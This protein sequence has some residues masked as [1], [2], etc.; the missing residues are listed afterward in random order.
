[1]L[2]ISITIA[3]TTY[4]RK[5][6]EFPKMEKSFTLDSVSTRD[7]W[8]KCICC[9]RK[10]QWLRLIDNRTCCRPITSMITDRIGFLSVLLLLFI[11]L[12]WYV[13][14]KTAQ[15]FSY[16]PPTQY[17]RLVYFY[18]DCLILNQVAFHFGKA[19]TQL[20]QMSFFIFTSL[21]KARSSNKLDSG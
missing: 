2:L 21:P 7:I 15:F 17:I 14:K 8:P 11:G 19:F 4:P 16:G 5:I 6:E 1:M 13:W 12:G 18:S 20:Y 10:L 3:T 9:L